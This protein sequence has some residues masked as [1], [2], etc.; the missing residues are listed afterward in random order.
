MWR[1][2]LQFCGPCLRN[3]YGEDAIEACKDQVRLYICCLHTGVFN[4]SSVSLL[5]DGAFMVLF[6]STFSVQCSNSIVCL[7]WI[8]FRKLLRLPPFSVK[9]PIWGT[10]TTTCRFWICFHSPDPEKNPGRERC[11]VSF[12]CES[13][14]SGSDGS[15]HDL[16][17]LCLV[18]SF[19]WLVLFQTWVCPPCRGIC[20]CSF[21]LA[22][23][24]RRP[25]GILIHVA[26]DNGF[27][28]VHSYLRKSMSDEGED[29]EWN[30]AHAACCKVHFLL[31]PPPPFFADSLRCQSLAGYLGLSL[32]DR[33][34]TDFSPTPS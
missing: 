23:K 26:R 3:R 22:R 11:S 28:S 31:S 33:F 8:Y 20:N 17:L 2:V 12:L 18:F 7:N 24:G 34:S 15:W 29:G 4:A 14:C 10:F 13:E 21:C 1:L 25:T 16:F 30:R 32:Q 27:D 6:V 19:V 5:F 9:M